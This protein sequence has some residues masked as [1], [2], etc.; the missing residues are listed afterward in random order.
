MSS[1][2]SRQFK[3]LFWKNLTIKKRNSL[4][5][6]LEYLLPIVMS[7]LILLCN[8]LMPIVLDSQGVSNKPARLA[9][10]TFNFVMTSAIPLLFANTCRF[11]MFQIVKE[12]EI[13]VYKSLCTLNMSSLAYA[14]SFIAIQIF[15]CLFTALLITLP[16]II[17]IND[18]RGVI[19][20]FLANFLFGVAMIV[21]SLTVTTLF[22]DSKFST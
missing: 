1:S 18:A 12:K 22:N 8:V 5:T 3:V 16:N 21:F 10:Y 14:L 17:I 13:M 20:F 15:N 9:F 2:F 4:D 6:K 19:L 7:A 11:I